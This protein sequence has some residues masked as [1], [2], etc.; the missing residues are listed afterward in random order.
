MLPLKPPYLGVLPR[1]REENPGGGISLGSQHH[2]VS[3]ADGKHARQACLQLLR[4]SYFTQKFKLS[5]RSKIHLKAAR[6]KS[7]IAVLVH[8][9]PDVP[10]ALAN[11]GDNEDSIPGSGRSSGG[12]GSEFKQAHVVGNWTGKP[13]MPQSTGS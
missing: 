5:T 6:S 10:G 7:T 1:D 12:G 2:L 8:I 11:A 4:L 9:C 3:H 13:G